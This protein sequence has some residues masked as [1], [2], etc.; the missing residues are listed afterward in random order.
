MK[1][2]QTRSLIS[3]I[4]AITMLLTGSMLVYA[5]DLSD[6]FGDSAVTELQLDADC[7]ILKYVDA[8]ALRANKHVARLKNQEQ[9]DTYVFQNRDGTRTVYFMSGPVKY[10]DSSGIIREKDLTLVQKTGGY[11]VVSSDMDVLLPLS[12]ET[13]I[14]IAHNGLS[15]TL[16]PENVSFGVKAGTVD[17]EA[18]RYADCFGSGIDLVY[19]P[20]LTGLKEDIVMERYFGKQQF[21]FLLETYGLK[22]YQRD[23]QYYLAGGENS[24]DKLWLGDLVIYDAMGKPGTGTMT[25]ETVEERQQYR[26]TLTVDEAFL[27]SEDTVFPVTVDP[28]VTVNVSDQ[29]STGAI[30]DAAVYLNKPSLNTGTWTYN[31][32]G[33]YDDNY[34]VG[35]TVYR[36]MGLKNNTSYH[37]ASASEV[38]SVKLYVKEASGSAYATVN[39]YAMNSAWTESS[40]TSGN[41]GTYDTST[42]YASASM[43][44]GYWG[45][46]DITA[47]A[48]AWKNGSRNIDHGLI[49]VN[50]NETSTAAEKTVY[51]SEFGTASYRPYVVATYYAPVELNQTSAEVNIGGTVQL[52]LTEGTAASW[53]SSNTY[54]ATVS[55][56]GVVT[57]VRAGT[58]T[59]TAT[60]AEGYTGTCTVTVKLPEDKYRFNNNSAVLAMSTRKTG[61]AGESIL[62]GYGS[63]N[64]VPAVYGQLWV[65]DRLSDGYYTISPS[66][67]PSLYLALNTD[68]DL[69][70]QASCTNAAQWKIYYNMFGYGYVLQNRYTGWYLRM[71][72]L[73]YDVVSST[74]VTTQ[75]YWSLNAQSIPTG[76][77]LYDPQTYAWADTSGTAYMNLDSG[78]QALCMPLE[79]GSGSFT[80]TTNS[81]A[82]CTST[83]II[84]GTKRGTANVT[85][86]ASVNGTTRQLSFPLA[87]Y[88]TISVVSYYDDSFNATYRGYIDEAV[89][90][91][92]KVYFDE[93]HLYYEVSGSP[94]AYRTIDS[95]YEQCTQS[96]GC[97][98]DENICG[99]DCSEH[100]KNARRMSQKMVEEL[101]ANQ[102]AVLWTNHSLEFFCEGSGYFHEP[103][104]AFAATYKDTDPDNQNVYIPRPATHIM[105]IPETVS[106]K[107]NAYLAI[108]LAH[109][110]AHTLR[111]RE[112]YNGNDLNAY[113]EVGHEGILDGIGSDTKKCIMGRYNSVSDSSYVDFYNDINSGVES[114]FCSY[115]LNKLKG[116]IPQI[117]YTLYNALPEETP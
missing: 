41:Y 31:H 101:E 70:I 18:Y 110:I 65:V 23:G 111:L 3:L 102:V 66:Y 39:L 53:S 73:N 72:T 68:S 19:T 105:H 115:C 109:E 96:A 5:V 30:E 98:N 1:I 80:I 88:K 76:I 11:G 4:L 113:G 63:T 24:D 51:S 84:T 36:L 60:D 69:V 62:K 12:A 114:A 50:P 74:T 77:V 38:T 93:F 87:V 108:V 75:G 20:T 44:Y 29:T 21:S 91:V 61:D 94:T 54:V 81:I 71:P 58:A 95:S 10:R 45:E 17:G 52:S 26:V 112:T 35:R 33:K 40:V 13:G 9:M 34:G 57:G 15:I 89:D 43:G 106:E 25:V 22:L 27:E 47:L 48:K 92:N 90:F 32:I 85:V 7:Q 6:L 99:E 49:L 46:F 103:T 8:D 97:D 104:D 37:N 2:R 67:K 116:E 64:A 83:G 56:S 42:L 28:T 100:H 59:I 55:S 82:S 14:E 86:S 117:P 107:I 79:Q 78:L 16:N